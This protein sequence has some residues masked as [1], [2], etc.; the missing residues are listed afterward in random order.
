M[1]RPTSYS[2]NIADA[3][4]DFLGEGLSLVQICE[5]EDIPH[6]STILRW[7]STNPGFAAKVARAREGGQADCLLDDIARIEAK[8][9]LARCRRMRP[10]S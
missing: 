4:C 6:R 9:R 2:D 1:S 5:R 7:M 3:I 8:L 10:V